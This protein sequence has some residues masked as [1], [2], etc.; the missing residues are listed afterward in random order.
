MIE[1]K[2]KCTYTVE[3]LV[4]CFEFTSSTTKTERLSL[5]HIAGYVAFKEKSS[6]TTLDKTAIAPEFD[7]EFTRMVSRG[8]L[9]YPSE[10]LYHLTLYLYAYYKS[11][12]DKRRINKLLTAFGK[13]YE[14][15]SYHI[16]NYS[17]VLRRL[18]NCFNI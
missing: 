9:S 14:Y 3:C 13:I 10:C 11:V 6:S 16:D 1:I 18:A 4:G 12:Q 5:I 17:S 7:S 15:T 8:K 2:C